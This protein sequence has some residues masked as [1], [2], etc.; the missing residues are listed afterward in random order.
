MARYIDADQLLETLYESYDKAQKWY[1]EAEEFETKIRAEQAVRTFLE[2]LLR[3][4]AQTT[5]DVQEVK[6]GYWSQSKKTAFSEECSV[7]GCTVEHN[8][9]VVI[10]YPRC[11]FCGAKMDGKENEE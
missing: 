8:D 3:T 5:A 1:E 2:C 9:G 4:K 7:C 11:P 6:H 10:R